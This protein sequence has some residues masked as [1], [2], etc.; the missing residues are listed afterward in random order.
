MISTPDRQR[1][2]EL[3]DDARRQGARLE[4]AC[5]EMGITARTSSAGRM[6]ATSARTSGR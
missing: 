2:V 4:A 1:A 5:H 3:I 6:M